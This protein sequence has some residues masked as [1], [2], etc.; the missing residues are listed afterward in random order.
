MLLH[1]K[2][3]AYG[4]ICLVIGIAVSFLSLNKPNEAEINNGLI[5][6]RL[7]LP[8]AVN[9]YYR[10][11]RFDWSGIIG[12]LNYKGHSYYAPWFINA[13]NPTNNDAVLG[14]VESFDPLGYDDAKKD[15][16][17]VKIGVG[18]LRKSNDSLYKFNKLY[19]VTNPGIW[20]IK[21]TSDEVRFTHTLNDTSYSY[22]YQKTVK[23]LKNKPVLELCH[24]LRNTGK[25]TIETA[26]FD[27]NFLV[28]DN[29]PT[30]SGLSVTF[31]FDLTGVE[32]EKPD[33]VKLQGNQMTFLKDLDNKFVSFVD[34][35][36]G[37]GASSYDM[38]IE[39]HKTGAAVRITADRP[40][41]KLAFW[42]APTTLCP[43]PY[44]NV[45]IDPGKEFTWKITYQYYTCDIV[46]L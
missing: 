31:Q 27:H 28:L 8:D 2:Y 46:K 36:K 40:I 5:T 18:V 3:K 39:N 23:L 21:T 26:V 17:F 1:S 16:T 10:G 6:A 15:G 41:S 9:G 37:E 32:N 12:S 33:L 7:Y 22:I 42:S 34:L 38:K 20:N 45:K 30:G 11:V 4:I 29:Q 24:T 13:Y 35:T 25:R 14:P 43:E 44:I 19:S